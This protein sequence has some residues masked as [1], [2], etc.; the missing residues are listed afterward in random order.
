[1]QDLAPA[2]HVLQLVAAVPERI[3]LAPAPRMHL[4]KRA[5]K[6]GKAGVGLQSFAADQ[7]QRAHAGWG[8]AHALE[9]CYILARKMQI[10]GVAG[11]KLQA[12]IGANSSSHSRHHHSHVT[13]HTSLTSTESTLLTAFG[14]TAA[15]GLPTF[16]KRIHLVVVAT[17]KPNADAA[18][19]AALA[20]SSCS[21][22]ATSK[23][24]ILGLTW[25][26]KASENRNHHITS[27]HITRHQ[28]CSHPK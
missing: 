28:V 13:R 23:S 4:H 1:M 12:A 22:S 5:K 27:H 2:A 19:A 17:L 10:G 16:P 14:F 7:P 21:S 26:Q 18:A 20:S 6:R 8:A 11:S 25:S 24:Q 3:Q 15:P 9:A